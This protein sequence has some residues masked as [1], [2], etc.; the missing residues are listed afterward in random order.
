MFPSSACEL[1]PAGTPP[2][3]D[4]GRDWGSRVALPYLIV[5]AL[6]NFGT[7]PD[8][9]KALDAAAALQC[10]KVL[11]AA[12]SIGLAIL[13]H[14][15]VLRQLHTVR[16]AVC[17]PVSHA[18]WRI[19]QMVFEV[20]QKLWNIAVR[21]CHKSL[22]LLALGTAIPVVACTVLGVWIE[23]K[24]PSNSAVELWKWGKP[25]SLH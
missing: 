4:P 18:F 23:L 3:R 14:M 1:D 15:V 21:C 5:T 16:K 12:I 25:C 2:A 7:F 9:L 8:L 17:E 11:D 6:I 24:V 20:F 13:W 22:L 19:H 10:C